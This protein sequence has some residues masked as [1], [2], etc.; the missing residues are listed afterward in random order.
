M[1]ATSLPTLVHM[2]AGGLGISLLPKLA[3]DAGVTSGADVELRPFN[4]PLIGRRIGIA[5]RTGSPRAA[6]AQMI[7]EVVRAAL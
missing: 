5:W 4:T 7:G 6:E 1:T 2:V 3:I